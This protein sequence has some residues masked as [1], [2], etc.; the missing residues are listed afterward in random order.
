MELTKDLAYRELQQILK[1]KVL[2]VV[3]TGASMALDPRFGMGALGEELRNKI[4]DKISH[5]RDA[6]KQW[7]KVLDKI[8]VDGDL[9]SALNEVRN[10][11]LIDT[12]I[13]VT[14]DF[15]AG[16][17]EG[18]KSK[19]LNGDIE[20]PIRFFLQKLFNGLPEYDPVLDIIT[21]NYD[22][23]LEYCCDT[24]EIPYITG[25]WGGIQKQ[26]NWEESIQQMIH[27]KD[28]PRGK[29]ILKIERT[30]RHIRLH[31]VHGSLNWFKKEDK[32][33]EDNTS[34][35][36]R[37]DEAS[38]IERFI[39]TPGES[40]YEKAFL[41]FDLFANANQAVSGESAFIFVGYGFNDVHIQQNIKKE[42]I[43]K[44]K[45]GIIITKELTRKADDLL[46]KSDNLWA[47]Y[48]KKK[49]E[50]DKEETITCIYNRTYKKPLIM[51][52]S[53]IWEIQRFSR[54]VLGD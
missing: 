17:E 20:I 52:N 44:N 8:N 50:N 54:E 14:G 47:V 30:R 1:D 27:T 42:I 7:E 51:E 48:Q 40:K 39:I 46:K 18:Y 6:V 11:V 31:K 15:V 36:T 4:P 32:I 25:F 23:L 26:Y 28:I 35:Y 19:I 2:L 9:E 49:G 34:V 43:E 10:K 41:N 24:Q 5:D 53:S 38:T 22:L 13:R 21:P 29:K 33:F 45:A 16:L 37:Q 12:I 3:G